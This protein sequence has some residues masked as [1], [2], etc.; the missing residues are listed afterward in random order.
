MRRVVAVLGVLLILAGVKL[1]EVRLSDCGFAG[2]ESVYADSLRY[3]FFGD[4]VSAWE[5]IENLDGKV[6]WS[7][8]LD[9]DVTVL[10][11]YSPRIYDSVTLQSRR[12]NLMVA[13]SNGQVHIGSPLLEGSY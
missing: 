10:Y 2:E 7:E 5:A 8:Q 9:C 11:A 13:V 12:V 3:D 1:Y 4:E 6:L